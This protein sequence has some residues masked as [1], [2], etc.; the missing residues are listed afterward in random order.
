MEHETAG[1]PVTGLKWTRKTT[2]KVAKEL[3]SLG[4]QVGP[5]KVAKLLKKL[6]FS[7]RVNHKKRSNGSPVER[8]A[9]F[10][11][12]AEL[13]Q[14]FATDGNPVVSVDAKKREHVGLFK[15]G[16][17]R[18]EQTPTAVNDHDF[19][20]LADG[21]AIPYGI[22]DVL[23]NRATIYVGMSYDTAHFAVDSIERWWRQEGRRRY[24]NAT[25]LAILADCGGSNGNRVRAWKYAVQHK[26]CNRHGLN[27]TVAHYPPGASKWNPIEHRVFAEISKNWAGVPLQSYETILKF[28]GTT[29]TETGLRVKA[30]LVRQRY[31]KGVKISD[32]QMREVRLVTHNH[33]PKWNYT[34]RPATQNTSI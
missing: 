21:V 32:K 5:R 4:I 14:Q 9:Q 3:Q 33:L 15:N 34:I 22:H 27:V 23:A 24:P 7:L 8:D 19:P 13:R 26:L 17:R 30:H 1:D 2:E 29:K 20:S 31:P 10:C 6:K 28:I 12:I 18:W 11:R 16:G 25:H